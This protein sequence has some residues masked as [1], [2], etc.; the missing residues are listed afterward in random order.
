MSIAVA[1]DS[2][3]GKDVIYAKSS[4]ARVLLFYSKDFT[5]FEVGTSFVVI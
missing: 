1:E 5:R 4:R 2:A 3:N